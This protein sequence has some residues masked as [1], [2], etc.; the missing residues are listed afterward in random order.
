MV[1]PLPL[2]DIGG[3]WHLT[4][5][6]GIIFIFLYGLFLKLKLPYPIKFLFAYLIIRSLFILEFPTLMFW[7]YTSNFQTTA[8]QM[9]IEVVALPLGAILFERYVEKILIFVAFFSSL[10]VWMKWPG[11]LQAPSFN[12]AFAALALP[13]LPGWAAVGVLI[14]IF[15]HHGSTALLI[16]AAQLLAYVLKRPL[17]ATAGYFLFPLLFYIALKHSGVGFDSAERL[18]NYKMFMAFWAKD[19]HWIVFGVGPGSFMWTSILL[20]KE[21]TSLFLQMHSDWLQMIWELGL[22][23]LGL[24]LWVLISA[25]KNAW[26]N[27]VLLSALFGCVAFGL[28]YHPL[29]FFP[30]AFLTAYIFMKAFNYRADSLPVHPSNSFHPK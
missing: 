9:L 1:D 25:V 16:V 27:D 3:V 15:T 26:K 10:C 23:G 14:T 18:Q 12:G 24:I 8:A 22:V 30:T 7:P 4:F 20:S 5:F 17:W 13:F 2:I 21:K 28:T 29:R 6:T 19:W 11:L